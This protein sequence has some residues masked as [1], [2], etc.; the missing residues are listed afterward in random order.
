MQFAKQGQWR[1]CTR[2]KI[3]NGEYYVISDQKKLV[4]LSVSKWILNLLLNC[5]TDLLGLIAGI[6]FFYFVIRYIYIPFFK[7]KQKGNSL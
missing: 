4:V 3:V 6:G 1:Q 2:G 5:V 7:D